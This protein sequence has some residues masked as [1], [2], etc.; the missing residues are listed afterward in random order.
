MELENEMDA[1][2]THAK[3]TKDTTGTSRRNCAKQ[4]IIKKIMQTEVPMKLNDLILTIP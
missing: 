4:N 2:K 3:E 1:E